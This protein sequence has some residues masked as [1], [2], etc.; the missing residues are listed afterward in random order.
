M[1]S[2]NSMG[3]AFPL[4]WPQGYPRTKARRRAIYKATVAKARD[5]IIDELRLM[6]I[7]DWNI[8]ISSNAPVSS[9]TMQMLAMRSEPADPGVAVYF[10]K[11][12][13]PFVF[14]CD[15]W[16]RLAD[17]LRAIA[18]TIEAMRGLDRWGCSEML[19]RVFQGFSALPPPAEMPKNVASTWWDV[20]EVDQRDSLDSIETMYRAKMRKAHPDQGG[21]NEAAQRLNLAIQEARRE[22]SR[23]NQ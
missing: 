8:I 21:T 23:A 17:N 15:K 20:L 4:D 19:E 16:D 3:E 7:G 22:K 11:Q 5:Q 13:K 9:R 2:Q 12:G 10:R 6:G 14:A 1:S 18:M